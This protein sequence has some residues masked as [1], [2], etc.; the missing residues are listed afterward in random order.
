M[1]V[2]SQKPY[3]LA[4][5]EPGFVCSVGEHDDIYATPPGLH[6]FLLSSNFELNNI[7]QFT[8]PTLKDGRINTFRKRSIPGLP[9]AD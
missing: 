6:F 8:L 9:D 1:Y 4:G 3:T 5:F 2:H 7:C